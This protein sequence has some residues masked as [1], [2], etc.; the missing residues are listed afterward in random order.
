MDKCFFCDDS[1]ISE[2]D[3]RPYS[4][5]S[6]YLKYKCKKCGFVSLYT[7][8]DIFDISYEQ[9]INDL[10]K[11]G[12]KKILCSIL[13]NRYEDDKN[14][15]KGKNDFLSIK[16]LKDLY[17]SYKVKDSIELINNALLRL[18]KLT[19]YVGEQ[20]TLNIYDDYP[21]FY[22]LDAGHMVP[23]FSLIHDS[24]LI[25]LNINS[26]LLDIN[27][28]YNGYNR[29]AELKTKGEG[30]QCFVAMWFNQKMDII[31]KAIEKAVEYTGKGQEKSKYRAVRIDNVE[32]NGDINDKIIAEIR[33]SKFMVC[34]LT[35]YR[36][37]VYFEAGFAYGLGLQVIYTCRKDWAE[38]QD[39]YDEYSNKIGTLY[40]KDGKP[41]IENAKIEG[42]HF[43]LAHRNRIEWEANDDDT[44]DEH[45][46]EVFIARLRDR[47]GATV[48]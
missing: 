40:N 11:G 26:V 15:L 43:D 18:D 19:N 3:E 22:C 12:R 13:R 31:Y 24:K 41:I 28:T 16:D 14:N 20:I 30:N 9:R 25:V 45:K 29:L 37:G 33:R 38:N 48:V 39:I 10:F 46:L 4:Q 47:I 32:H 44:V 34:D 17:E 35:G 7:K 21:L 8:S 27:I 6:S 42:V 36:G 5:D 1:N 23:F 2:I